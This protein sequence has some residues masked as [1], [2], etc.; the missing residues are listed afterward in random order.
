[1]FE[2]SEITYDEDIT[3]TLADTQAAIKAQFSASGI[4]GN[5]IY[6]EDDYE[7]EISKYIAAPI[8]NSMSEFVFSIKSLKAKEKKWLGPALLLKPLVESFEITYS[9]KSKH[10]NG[11]LNGS[12]RY[13]KTK[14]IKAN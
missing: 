10:S 13:T 9:I 1:M 12:I 11:D 14:D 6:D 4:N 3:Y 2:S 5:P 8:E 7:R